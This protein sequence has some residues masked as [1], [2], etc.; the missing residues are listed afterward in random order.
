MPGYLY[1]KYRL[2]NY[3]FCKRN[4]LLR[5][6]NSIL[7]WSYFASKNHCNLHVVWNFVFYIYLRLFKVAKRIRDVSCTLL[8]VKKGRKM[9]KLSRSLK[10][11]ASHPKLSESSTHLYWSILYNHLRLC[12]LVLYRNRITHEVAPFDLQEHSRTCGYE[13]RF[14]VHQW[15]HHVSPGWNSRQ[16]SKCLS[17]LMPS[18]HLAYSCSYTAA[19]SLIATYSS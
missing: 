17:S 5:N 4:V 8:E 2:T 16:C 3:I 10:H 15:S 7:R 1:F 14:P 9:K 11:T 12:T 13:A 19:L 6:V 18:H